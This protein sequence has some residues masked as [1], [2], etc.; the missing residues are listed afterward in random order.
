MNS[1]GQIA[2]VATRVNGYSGATAWFYD[3]TANQTTP[4]EFSESSSG[5]AS[6]AVQ[7]LSNDGACLGTYAQFDGDTSLGDHVFY[8]SLANGFRDLGSI[9]ASGFASQGWEGLYNELVINGNGDAI[10][11]GRLGQSTVQ[12][13]QARRFVVSASAAANARRWGRVPVMLTAVPEPSF[14]ASVVGLMSVLCLRRVRK[15]YV[16]S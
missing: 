4:L 9:D 16:G 8:W 2:G 5:I 15:W 10:S 7:Y 11:Y 1:S 6:S 13:M 3:P 14:L 12:N